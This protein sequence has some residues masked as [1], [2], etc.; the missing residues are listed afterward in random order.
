MLDNQIEVGGMVVANVA[1]Y[2]TDGDGNVIVELWGD[3]KRHDMGPGLAEPIR[4]EG[5]GK[6]VWMTKEL[7]GVG[8]T[9]QYLHDGRATT[10]SE[11]I[12]EHGGDAEDTQ[13]AFR[14]LAP[15]DQANLIRFL[16]NLVVFKL[17]E[18]EE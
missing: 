9:N 15:A 18:E 5:I 3:L 17:A 12:L 16:K 10:L 7:W 14:A 6:S 2:L 11:A 4:D 13:L 1:N 8:S